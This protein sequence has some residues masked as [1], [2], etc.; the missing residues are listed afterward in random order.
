VVIVVDEA[1][2]E[3]RKGEGKLA[4]RLWDICAY[5]GGYVDCKVV[6]L[7]FL[8]QISERGSDP[9]RYAFKDN[10]ILFFKVDDFDE[11]IQTFLHRGQYD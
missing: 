6:S 8:Q 1:E 3:K 2:Y 11:S 10:T 5:A 9:A 7:D 4:F